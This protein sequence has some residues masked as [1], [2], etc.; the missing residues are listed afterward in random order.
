MYTVQDGVRTLQFEGEKIAQS[1]SRGRNKFRWVEFELFRTAKGRYVISRVG[2]SLYFHHS[3][4]SVVRRNG[5]APVPAEALSVNLMPCEDCRPQ[6][7]LDEELFPE[8]PRYFAQ[9]FKYAEDVVASLKRVD[10]NG[11]EYFTDVARRLLIEAASNDD[12]I[13]DAFFVEWI[14]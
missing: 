5:I 14:E 11:E 1:S 7:G 12:D 2:M 6:R 3:G 8:T 4:C 13:H 10:D 9:T